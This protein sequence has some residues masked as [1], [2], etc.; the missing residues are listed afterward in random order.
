MIVPDGISPLARYAALIA[1]VPVIQLAEPVA[2]E[3]G[4]REGQVVQGVVQARG[5]ALLFEL[6]GRFFSLPPS[7]FRPAPGDLRWFRVVRQGDSFG[8]RALAPP[9]GTGPSPSITSSS[10]LAPASTA[11]QIDPCEPLPTSRHAG[12]M[13][14]PASIEVLNQ[15]LVPGRLESDLI[16]AGEP[17]LAQALALFRVR[18]ESLSAQT[19]Q[20]ALA[21]SGVWTEAMLAMGRPLSALDLKSLLRQIGRVLG[22]RSASS[23][24]EVDEVVDQIERKQ[25]ESVQSQSDGRYAI[26]MMLPFAG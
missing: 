7:S 26:S 23:G 21:R 17:G 16:D 11:V 2:R 25:L 19:L 14:R 6:G 9:P 13:A 22:A 4:L 12:L 3:L 18:T 5:E 8:L 24:A 1:D 20:Q 15:L 10:S